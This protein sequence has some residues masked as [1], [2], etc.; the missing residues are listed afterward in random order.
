MV[1]RTEKDDESL[2]SEI[3]QEFFANPWNCFVLDMFAVHD[4]EMT[5]KDALKSKQKGRVNKHG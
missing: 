3:M 5:L 4:G 1:D 2:M